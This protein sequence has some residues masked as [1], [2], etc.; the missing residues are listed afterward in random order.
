M[1][2]ADP[3]SP[4][5]T[6]EQ[7]EELA[8]TAADAEDESA[9][10]PA[11]ADT[12]DLPA[13]GW[14]S[15]FI[16]R[17]AGSPAAGS[18][19]ADHPVDGPAA[20]DS[21]GSYPGDG[22]EYG[23]EDEPGVDLSGFVAFLGRHRTSLACVAVIVASLIWK[24]VFV[25]HYYFRQDDFEIIDLAL[26]NKL[27][28]SFL[29]Q[30]YDGHFFPGVFAIAW[31]LARA[32]LYN[33]VVGEGVVVVFA[34][35]ASVAAWRLLRSLFG[36]R[37][38]IV[39]PLVLYL[40]API[41]FDNYSVW[42]E[43]IESLPM[44]LAI[45][46]TLLAHVRYVR[47]GRFRYAVLAA[48]WL[49][50]GLIFDEKAAVIPLL[51]FAVTAGF[52]ARKRGFLAAAWSCLRQLWRAW[53]LYAGLLAVY[54]VVLLIRLSSS[55]VKPGVPTSLGAIATFSSRSLGLVALPGMLG[56]PWRWLPKGTLGLAYA[57][58]P[59][60]LA[61]LAA[62]VVVAFI[63]A[64][65][66]VRRRAWRAWAILAGWIVLADMLPIVL[67]RLSIPGLPGIADLL[68]M[69]SRYVSDSAAIVAIA[70]GLAWLPIRNAAETT[71]PVAEPVTGPRR[72][73]FAGRWKLVALALTAIFILGSVWSVQQYVHATTP[74]GAVGRS[75]IAD[76]RLA[77][78][79]TPPGTVIVNSQVPSNLM[80]TLFLNHS[81]TDTVLGPL[82]KPGVPVS[83]ISRPSGYYP[84]LK[85]FGTDGRL[86]PASL[87]GTTTTAMPLKDSC[88]SL[89]RTRL[90]MT[91]PAP[92]QFAVPYLSVGYLA[93][94]A[95]AG[96]IVTVSYGSVVRQMT[97]KA[98]LN[99][100]YFLVSGSA[101]DVVVDDP[102]GPGLC[103]G[104]AVA[105]FSFAPG[106]GPVIPAQP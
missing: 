42:N 57:W 92:T 18:P 95:A 56:G 25:S 84:S 68:G 44:Q 6:R 33:W 32:A 72:E 21:A 3:S 43:G 38:A 73:Y 16:R 31:V 102:D 69:E 28:W 41:G 74:D 17:A 34:A 22:D 83:W 47:T 77:L 15:R 88:S 5:L 87:T 79:Q 89:K 39:I 101:R 10:A 75:Y 20:A 36:D 60:A 55:T 94:P 27:S 86:Y 19:A 11:D 81:D 50:F 66:V 53:A 23:D 29:T 40:M 58:P 49:T 65:I 30:G 67:G 103:V 14:R 82:R 71:E 8:S 13:R 90:T 64:T 105:G 63:A 96:E 45:F 46:A 59:E 98:G 7:D 106:L 4:E 76:A 61:W 9:D 12:A 91:F 85:I 52:L 48:G 24:I 54:V 99:A 104:T 26:K 78:A 2:D 51:L 1:R 100:A 97:I 62:F 35:A 80:I 37:I 70:V 93:G